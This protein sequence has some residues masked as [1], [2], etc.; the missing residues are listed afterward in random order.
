M[1][2]FIKLIY[3]TLL[4]VSLAVSVIYNSAI[5]TLLGLGL[6][7][8][9]V[10]FTYIS[11]EEYA[12]KVLLDTTISNQI[13]KLN[14]IL[15]TVN[16]EGNVFFLPPYY[17]ED[18]D[19]NKICVTKQKGGKLPKRSQMPDQDPRLFI[20][21]IENPPS[22]LLTPPGAELSKLFEDKFGIKFAAVGLQYL[23]RKMPKL[24]IEDLEIVQDFEMEI[25]NSVIRVKIEK[26]VYITL[27]IVIGE[28]SSIYALLGSPLSNAIAFTLAKTT[29]KSITIERQQATRNGR[30]AVIEYRVL[31][32]EG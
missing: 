7:F 8:W 12:K 20:N 16:Y 9:G 17:F 31:E 1:R 22:V 25:E 24:L 29:D 30:D 21:F 26:S 3:T 18:S 10:T 5:L 28:S 4:V 13:A 14:K 11:T 27:P 15:Q 32:A 2:N 6:V 19:T 23:R